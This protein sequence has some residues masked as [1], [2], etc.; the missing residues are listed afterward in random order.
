MNYT[1]FGVTCLN[2]S[3]ASCPTQETY[4]WQLW[5]DS[6]SNLTETDI[7]VSFNGESRSLR[8]FQKDVKQLSYR[9]GR[10]TSDTEYQIINK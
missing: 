3:H 7:L 9:I 2:T 8:K 4:Q 5:S 1:L 6:N 10:N